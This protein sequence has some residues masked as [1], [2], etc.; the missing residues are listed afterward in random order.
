[1]SAIAS[2]DAAAAQTELRT[3]ISV[4]SRAAKS[5][6]IHK[7]AVSR[8]QSRLTKAANAKAAAVKA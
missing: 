7:N 2:G 6:I 8:L 1:L 5:N 4:A 3:A